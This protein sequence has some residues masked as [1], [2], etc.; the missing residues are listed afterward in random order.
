MS[1]DIHKCLVCRTILPVDAPKSVKTISCIF[2]DSPN[3]NPANLVDNKPAKY[4]ESGLKTKTIQLYES[5]ASLLFTI[6]TRAAGVV[7]IFLFASRE[8]PTN[9]LLAASVL[10]L[11]P[12]FGKNFVQAHWKN[13]CKWATA[14]TGDK[15][16]IHYS[17]LEWNWINYIESFIF[18]VWFFSVL[19]FRFVHADDNNIIYSAVILGAIGVWIVDLFIAISATC[20][21]HLIPRSK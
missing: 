13:V 6:L 14:E 21:G 10:V 15:Y 1:N 17:A 7:L 20:L 18:Q 8:I 16:Q 3:P 9:F 19:M 11:L 5:T 2:C 4:L 12:N